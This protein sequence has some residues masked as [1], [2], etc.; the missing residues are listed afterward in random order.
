MSLPLKV[1]F[2]LEVLCLLSLH[3]FY[4][5]Q[6]KNSESEKNTLINPQEA[7][8]DT[9]SILCCGRHDIGWMIPRS[10]FLCGLITRTWSTVY[11]L[12]LETVRLVLLRLHCHTGDVVSDRRPQ[13]VKLP[14][15]HRINLLGSITSQLSEFHPRTNEENWRWTKNWKQRC[16]AW[17]PRIPLPVHL[18]YCEFNMTTTPRSALLLVFC[19]ATSLSP[20]RCINVH[21][22]VNHCYF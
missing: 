20:F 5:H 11:L 6:H 7:M 18:N 3:Y 19:S 15:K 2:E 22:A 17:P 9:I 13:F 10:L 14:S 21:M 4:A 8:S 12:N 1:C 16:G